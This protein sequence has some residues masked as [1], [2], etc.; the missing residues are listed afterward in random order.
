MSNKKGQS[1]RPPQPPEVDRKLQFHLLQRVGIPLMILIPV[2][3][4][5]GIFGETVDEV[6][7]SNLYLEMHV[8]FPTRFRYKMIDS[9]TVSLHNTS[10]RPLKT[11]KVTFDRAYLQGFS[12][13][14]FTPSVEH[15]TEAVYTVELTDLQPGEIRVISVSIQAEKYGNHQGDIVAEPDNSDGVQAS[16]NTFTFP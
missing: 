9:I 10:D 15:V 6:T 11:V 5:F 7:V 4:L 14:A 8:K 2:L 12:T 13:V 1:S 3:A 16:I